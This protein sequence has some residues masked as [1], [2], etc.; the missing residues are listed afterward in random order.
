MSKAARPVMLVGGVPGNSAEEVFRTLAP[1]L[2]DLA[3]GFTVGAFA[4]ALVDK[5]SARKPLG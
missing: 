3:V 2:G 5:F 4:T 1:I